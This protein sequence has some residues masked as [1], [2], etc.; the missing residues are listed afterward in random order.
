M[1]LG[2]GGLLRHALDDEEAELR[3]FV[4]DRPVFLV[5]CRVVPSRDLIHAVP[6]LNDEASLERL[7]FKRS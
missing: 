5:V 2:L 3:I 6:L 1:L 4:A 7:S